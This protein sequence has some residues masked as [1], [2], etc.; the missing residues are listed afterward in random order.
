[1][2]ALTIGTT[3]IH[4]QDGLFS[5][6]DFHQA[7]GGEKKYQPAFFL[8]NDQTKAFI[9]EISSAN[10]QII[11]IKVIRGRGKA[12]GTYACRELVI[13]YAAWI[14][15]AF[16]LKVIQ[17]FLE[18]TLPA[19]PDVERQSRALAMASEVAAVAFRTAFDAMMTGADLTKFDRWIVYLRYNATTRE[20]D[21]PYAKPIENEAFI[22]TVPRL[23]KMIVDPGCMISKA[24]M[25]LLASACSQEL[26]RRLA[27]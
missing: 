4:Q 3:T 7:S 12:Q 5:L 26:A 24:E 21:E 16:H 23:A 18:R 19:T 27:A 10:L 25:A 11:S 20:F 14:S 1:M 15:A 17:V 9:K 8:R 22:G 2:N 13:A 6:N